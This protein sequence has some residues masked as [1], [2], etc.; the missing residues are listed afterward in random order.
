MLRMFVA[1]GTGVIGR[2]VVPALVG[3]GHRVV[4]AARS[5][6]GR[7][8][9]AAQ[10]TTAVVVDL[11]DA[12]AVRKA[13]GEQDIVINLSTHIPSST[14]KMLLA[15]SWRE[16]DRVRRLGSA[17]LAA[18]AQAGG[19]DCFIQE[20]FA[21]IYQDAGDRW[22]DEKFRVMPA[23]YNQSVLDAEASAKKFNKAGGRGIVLRFGAFYGPDSFATRDMIQMV[24]KGTNPL[25]GSPDAYVSSIS[26]DD[27]AA[28]V[29]S[30]VHLPSGTYNVVDDEPVTRRAWGESLAAA[31]GVKPPAP[32]PRL[33]AKLGGS[34][35]EL[36]SRSQRISNHKLHEFSDWEPKARSIGD[37]WPAL[38]A[39][40]VK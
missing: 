29:V 32:F 30:A 24:R 13:M 10:G 5:E 1:G 18:A 19:A 2:R 6:E 38:L 31:L 27:A 4:A 33:I 34:T 12:D 40:L 11:F 22:I 3:A 35:V 36:L 21:G 15:W 8:K 16:N 23:K 20:S 9:L 7:A 25:P 39:A 37:A 26:H 28:A 17:N 14:K